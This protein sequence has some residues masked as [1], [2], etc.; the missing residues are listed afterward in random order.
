M[1]AELTAAMIDWRRDLHAHPE[2][3]FEERWRVANVR[4]A[5]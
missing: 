5:K 1:D 2:F 3:G 4:R